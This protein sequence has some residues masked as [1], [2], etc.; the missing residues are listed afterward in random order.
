MEWMIPALYSIH[1]PKRLKN[2]TGISTNVDQV[3]GS[4]QWLGALAFCRY[5]PSDRLTLLLYNRLSFP[6]FTHSASDCMSVLYIT[7]FASH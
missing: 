4:G 5:R 1:H 6:L 3:A 7:T 2:K